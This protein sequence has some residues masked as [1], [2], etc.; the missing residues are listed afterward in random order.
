MPRILL[1]A[2]PQRG[3]DGSVIGVLGMGQDITALNQQHKEALRIAD[4]LGRIVETTRAH[5]RRGCA[6]PRHSGNQK[7]AELSFVTK[8]EALGKSL[9]AHFITETV[10]E[11]VAVLLQ[12]ALNAQQTESFNLPLTKDGEEKAVLLP[13]AT[14]RK[15]PT[16]EVTGVICIGQ[17]ITQINTMDANSSASPTTWRG[18]STAT[19]RRSSASTSTAW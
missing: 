16:N 3:D 18:S 7:L 12:K 4:D 9:V 8:K 17:D 14:A 10:K 11:R 6:G 1:N 15:G 13:N 19:T 2:T 5:L